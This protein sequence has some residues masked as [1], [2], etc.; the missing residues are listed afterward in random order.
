MCI[1]ANDIR[2]V[3]EHLPPYQIA[4]NGRM[5]GGSSYLIMEEVLKR[6]NIKDVSEVM[7]WARAYEMGLSRDNTIIY[8]ITRSPERE[9]LFN[10]IRQLHHMEYSFFSTKTNKKLNIKTIE[11]ALN[12]R[13]VAVRKS[14]EASSLKRLGFIE[15]KN[16]ILVVDYFTAWQMLKV[17]RADI[18]YANAPILELSN[19]NSS[20]F[21]RQ[22][23]VI[24]KFQLYVAANINTDKKTINN[25]SSA[26]HSVKADSSFK[27]LFNLNTNE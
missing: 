14:F 3:T 24:E 22:G 13:A 25:L 4:E 10:W 7:P 15:G 12:Y 2:I 19:M 17:G 27:K 18:T 26:F 8:S 5:V 21:K 9:L 16:L 20:L 23:G 11:N 1:R 6:V